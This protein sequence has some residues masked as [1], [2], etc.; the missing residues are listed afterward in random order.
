MTTG[1]LTAN[2]ME[3]AMTNDA[4]ISLRPVSDRAYLSPRL[5]GLVNALILGAGALL[6]LLLCFEASAFAKESTALTFAGARQNLPHLVG[7]HVRV[8]AWMTYQPEDHGT[9]ILRGAKES[10]FRS[11]FDRAPDPN[12]QAD[13][14][15]AGGHDSLFVRVHNLP[16]ETRVWMATTCANGCR[17]NVEGA[18][19]R[20]AAGRV[21]LDVDG[22]APADT[23]GAGRPSAD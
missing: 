2:G 11:L 17:V 3:L 1:G 21:T 10:F 22:V 18:V 13:G 8:T 14:P 15:T 4:H 7:D 16:I 20:N 12:A 23:S 9:A 5:R 19:V 6:A